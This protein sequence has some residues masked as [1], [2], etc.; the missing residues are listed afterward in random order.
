M[1]NG[2]LAQHV[3]QQKS[4]ALK[5]H[6]SGMMASAINIPKKGLHNHFLIVQRKR[7]FPPYLLT[8]NNGLRFQSRF[9]F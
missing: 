4:M 8:L 7:C 6:M 9:N 3:L 5:L 1:I 2:Y